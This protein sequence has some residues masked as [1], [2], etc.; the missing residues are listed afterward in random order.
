LKESAKLKGQSIGIGTGKRRWNRE[1]A[2][3]L[4]AIAGRKVIVKKGTKRSYEI[5]FFN[6]AKTNIQEGLR[7]TYGHIEQ[8]LKKTNN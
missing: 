1:I 4:Q 5:P 8:R 7:K 2:R 3:R 6:Y